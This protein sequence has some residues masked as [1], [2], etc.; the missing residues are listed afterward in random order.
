M[1]IVQPI[2]PAPEGSILDV[3]ARAWSQGQRAIFP[4]SPTMPARAGAESVIP[5]A[6]DNG[7][8]AFKGA[9]LS[10]DP[11]APEGATRAR[12]TTVRIP[13][14]FGIAEDIQGKQEVT[15]H[16]D[17]VTFWIGEIALA[18]SG[19]SLRIGPTNHRLNDERQLWFLGACFVELLRAATY[20]PGVHRVAL[21]LAIPNTEF[22][23]IPDERTGKERL[24][25]TPKTREAIARHLKGKV[26]T[27]TRTDNQRTPET[28]TISV[29]TV[30]PHA[31]TSGTIMALTL[32][33]NGKKAI[34][35][36]GLRA[37]DI[38]GGDLHDSEFYFGRHGPAQMLNRRIGDGTVRI[39]RVL[40]ADPLLRKDIRNDVEAQNVL[41]TERVMRA[42]RWVSVTEDVRRVVASSGQSIVA[43]VIGILRGSRLFTVITGGGVLRLNGQLTEVLYQEEKVAGD[44]YVLV[45]G[46]LASLLNVIGC[47]FGMVF[48]SNGNGK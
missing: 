36:D 17:G 5:V 15:Y 34:D 7:N 44:D 16:C 19:D 20:A 6:G 23:I 47:L 13:A 24:T 33:P 9:T 27:I 37:I 43:D 41:I 38:G 30:L 45:D 14:A 42:G 1:Q 18:H 11:D 2:I 39:A 26:W 35:L 22:E 32:T 3:T 4:I 31:Q 46:P 40:R 28:W 8:D 21:S 12:L 10:P 48:R 25:A 29:T